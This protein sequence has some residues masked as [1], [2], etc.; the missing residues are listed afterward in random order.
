MN[1]LFLKEL[2]IPRQPTIILHLQSQRKDVIYKQWSVLTYLIMAGQ[3][4][5]STVKMWNTTILNIEDLW[6]II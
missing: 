5:L 1:V 3:Q 4:S 6:N 2:G